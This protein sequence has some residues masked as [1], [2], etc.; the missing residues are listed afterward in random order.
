VI[1]SK[2]LVASIRICIEHPRPFLWHKGAD[3]SFY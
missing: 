3:K 2:D 1:R